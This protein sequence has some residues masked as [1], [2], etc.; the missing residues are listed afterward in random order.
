MRTDQDLRGAFALLEE[1]ADE[2]GI[3][4]FSVAP[5]KP[6]RARRERGHLRRNA[7]AIAVTAGVVGGGIYAATSMGSNGDETRP[8]GPPPVIGPVPSPVK[9]Q[10]NFAVDPVA[11]AKVWYGGVYRTHQSAD[12]TWNAGGNSGAK[13][14]V[15]A[16]RAFN[17]THVMADGTKVAVGKHDGYWDTTP[18]DPY[19]THQPAPVLAWKYGT[20]SWATITFSPSSASLAT[21]RDQAIAVAKAVHTGVMSTLRLP[22]KIGYLPLNLV[23]DNAF[24]M[25]SG[26]SAGRIGLRDGARPDDAAMGGLWIEAE[27]NVQH[28]ETTCSRRVSVQGTTACFRNLHEYADEPGSR[29]VGRELSF[30]TPARMVSITIDRSHLAMYS[31]DVLVK[32]AQSL[33]F[34]GSMTDYNT[35]FDAR[36]ALPN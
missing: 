9:L 18:A 31:D 29:I 10:F 35:W 14:D 5:A 19:N 27:Q 11:G 21:M 25:Q 30:D 1:Q 28:S 15:Y 36:T 7:L 4:D 17:P 12:L 23:S 20:N 34:A 8:A 13:L 33:V 24:V 26:A 6:A 16:P 2:Y 22:F 3:P 32:I